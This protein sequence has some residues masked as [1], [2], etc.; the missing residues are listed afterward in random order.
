MLCLT[1]LQQPYH[2][3]LQPM[4]N[5]LQACRY[6]V[7]RTTTPHHGTF[8][9]TPSRE[10][11][12]I[13][14]FQQ[15]L[16]AHSPSS[17]VASLPLSFIHFSGSSSRQCC[18]TNHAEGRRW[19]RRSHF[20]GNVCNRL[21]HY[22]SHRRPHRWHRCFHYLHFHGGWHAQALLSEERSECG[23]GATRYLLVGSR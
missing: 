22:N 1:K 16:S 12:G 21:Q 2:W 17:P 5:T 14:Q 23:G 8:H 9:P 13:A 6:V 11:L 20:L 18:Y 10:R 7:V 19:S 3:N 15:H 4:E